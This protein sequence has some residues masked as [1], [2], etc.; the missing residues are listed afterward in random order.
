MNVLGVLPFARF[1]LEQALQPGDHAVD[2]TVGNGH[3][4]LF[5]ANLVGKDGFVYG[6][7]IQEQAILKA[8]DRLKDQNLLSRVDLFQTG[9]EHVRQS[10]PTQHHSKLKGAIFN[11]GYLPGGDKSIVTQPTSTL[12]A[13]SALLEMM[14]AGGLIVLVIYHGHEEGK[15]EKT[16]VLS[17]VEQIDQRLAHVLKYEFINQANHPPFVVA[18]E[19]R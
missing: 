17:F 16:S 18:I 4:T 2:C 15:Q 19:K 1:L 13:V 7:D 14:P 10:I 12:A 11:L 3:D 6:F 5:L 9:H 8:S